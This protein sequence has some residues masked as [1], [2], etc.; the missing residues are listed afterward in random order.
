MMNNKNAVS[1]EF[2]WL[3]FFRAK[4]EIWDITTNKQINNHTVRSNE[5]KGYCPKAI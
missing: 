1:P 4:I 3:T 5:I 2:L